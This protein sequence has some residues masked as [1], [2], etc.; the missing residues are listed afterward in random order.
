MSAPSL[1][2]WSICRVCAAVLPPD[3]SCAHGA[4]AAEG[5]PAVERG[6]PREVYLGRVAEAKLGVTPPSGVF[7]Y[8]LCA[9]VGLAAMSLLALL[10]QA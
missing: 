5:P 7:L 1:R 6:E 9:G 4:G 2:A 8:A 3:T 10:A